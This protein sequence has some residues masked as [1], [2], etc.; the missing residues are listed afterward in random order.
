MVTAQSADDNADGVIAREHPGMD[1]AEARIAALRD[2]IGA[3]RDVCTTRDDPHR[4]ERVDG[5][6][7]DIDAALEVLQRSLAVAVDRVGEADISAARDRGW[8]STDEAAAALKEKRLRELAQLRGSVGRD[9]PERS[10]S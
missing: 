6:K 3:W 10:G 2:A 5:T 7:E 1:E 8:L 9:S 4:P